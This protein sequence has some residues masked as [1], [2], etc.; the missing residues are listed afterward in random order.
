MRH[1]DF[2]QQAFCADW[3]V[4]TIS[5]TEH[6]AQFAVAGPLAKELLNSLLDAPLDDAAFP[7]L[8]CGQ[9]QLGGIAARLYRISFSGELGYE[10]AVPARYGEALYR[11][12]VAMPPN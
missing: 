9:V 10:I 8:S 4:R 5:V 2:V 3:D 1:L 12:L 7:F 11:D 6:S